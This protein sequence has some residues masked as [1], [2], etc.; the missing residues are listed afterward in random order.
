MKKI[1]KEE[2]LIIDETPSYWRS[3]PLTR[4]RIFF[5]E[6]NQ[7]DRKVNRNDEAFNRIKA[8][9]FSFL[10]TP[11]QTFL[12]YGDDSLPALYAQ[13]IALFK[14]SKIEDALKKADLLLKAE[15]DNP[16]F[17]EL[18]GQILFECGRIDEAV[19]SYRR[20]VQLR[21]K[22]DLI[23]L[24]LAHALLETG[25]KENIDEAVSHLEK[26]TATDRDFPEN[27]W[28]LHIAYAKQGQKDLSDYAKI[29]YDFLSGNGKD[30]PQRVQTLKKKMQNDTVKYNLLSDIEESLA[31]KD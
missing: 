30:L 22:A 16:Y 18:K 3:H 4:D 15:P 29:E 31:Q 28:F 25:Q 8:K 6:A 20:A 21:P 9:I 13:S 27:W 1:E 7:T 17:H 26:I 11:E 10:K 23:R 19:Q 24:S 14:Q 5:L 12:H 2:R